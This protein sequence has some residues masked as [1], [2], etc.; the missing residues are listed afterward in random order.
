M[1]TKFTMM[2]MTNNI[3]T[4]MKYANPNKNRKQIALHLMYSFLVLVPPL[5]AAFIAACGG[6]STSMGEGSPTSELCPVGAGVLLKFPER[7]PGPLPKPS[8]FGPAPINNR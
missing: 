3:T 5:P 2:N 1:V 7:E 8:A 4:P 6:A